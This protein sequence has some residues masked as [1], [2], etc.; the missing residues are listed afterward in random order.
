[1][2]NSLAKAVRSGGMT[3]QEA[4]FTWLLLGFTWREG[5]RGEVNRL[6]SNLRW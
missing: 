6:M 4:R 2:S 1:M 3:Q 5:G